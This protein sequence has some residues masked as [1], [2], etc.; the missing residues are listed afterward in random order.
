MRIVACLL[1]C[2]LL[3]VVCFMAV[4]ERE[5]AVAAGGQQA[6]TRSLSQAD[7]EA[8]SELG[9][10]MHAKLDASNRI[11]EGL[12]TD[13]MKKVKSGADELLQMSDAEQWRAS[14]DML[15]LQHSRT[16]RESVIAL[17]EKAGRGSVDGV[18]LAWMD[19]TLNC[20]RC[21]E[22][23]RNV[24]VAEGESVPLGLLREE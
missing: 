24:L 9:E 6:E 23:V 16:F 1:G 5:P 10:F 8:S 7:Q 20:I 3:S 13:Q 21:H 22:W 15:Y 18:A 14:N 12:V 19:V 2:G 11:L 4:S 17:R